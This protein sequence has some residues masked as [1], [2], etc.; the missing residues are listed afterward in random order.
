[1]KADREHP[2]TLYQLREAHRSHRLRRQ[3]LIIFDNPLISFIVDTHSP[4]A[5]GHPQIEQYKYTDQL[6]AT[7]WSFAY[8]ATQLQQ[9][10]LGKD[11]CRTQCEHCT[12]CPIWYTTWTKP[13]STDNT[14]QKPLN[15]KKR[16]EL[17]VSG[18]GTARV[19]LRCHHQ[20][21]N[22]CEE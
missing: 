7:M 11:V 15:Q 14:K 16:K 18:Y 22:K 10:I 2:L 21:F 5:P 1:M 9:A 6:F 12:T 13:S 17:V 20:F 4:L 8:D 19:Q 3:I